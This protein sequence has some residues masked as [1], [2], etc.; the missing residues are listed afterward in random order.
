[1]L[2]YPTL[3]EY[4]TT[5]VM[6]IVKEVLA[7]HSLDGKKL[8]KHLFFIGAM[9]PYTGVVEH[10]SSNSTSESASVLQ[11]STQRV[12]YTGVKNKSLEYVVRP[13]HASLNS[14]VLDFG[15]FESWHELQFVTALCEQNDKYMPV[16]DIILRCQ[17]F[18]RA[19]QLHNIKV[20]IRDILRALH[21][22]D[23]FNNSEAGEWLLNLVNVNIAPNKR[24]VVRYWR[25]VI[26]A[27][28]I[29]YYFRLPACSATTPSLL[30]NL[31]AVQ[32][33]STFS[34]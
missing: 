14:I 10:Q 15:N 31:R 23:Y 22:L 21:L 3:D 27:I 12:D 29:A 24:A 33:T 6:G 2:I 26:I 11:S 20:S 7:D 25:S 4:N 28:S 9:N 8:S 1:M 13:C 5:S 19:A 30:P 17:E 32:L 18:V 34:V 16:R